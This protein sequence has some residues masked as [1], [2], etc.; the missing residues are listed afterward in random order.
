MTTSSTSRYPTTSTTTTRPQFIQLGLTQAIKKKFDCLLKAEGPSTDGCGD[1]I[2][3][4]TISMLRQC[5]KRALSSLP[6]AAIF[7]QYNHQWSPG[8]SGSAIL[9]EF[10]HFY[11]HKGMQF[12]SWFP[13]NVLHSTCIATRLSRD[14]ES[15]EIQPVPVKSV[16]A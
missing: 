11:Y 10:R 15:N 16:I 12:Y 13:V 14:D 4:F 9:L 7:T 3:A 8:K 2:A 5:K 6:T 1:Y